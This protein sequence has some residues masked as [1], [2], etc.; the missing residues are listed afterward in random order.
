MKFEKR[1]VYHIKKYSLSLQN[2]SIQ[3]LGNFY[4]SN[5]VRNDLAYLC[6]LC[7]KNKI[8]VNGMDIRAD[9][10]FTL[11]HFPPA[12][13]SGK[14][15]ILVCKTCNDKAG[16]DFD[17]SLKEWLNEQSFIK[18][19]PNA[20][21]PVKIQPQDLKGKYR[22]NLK[23]EADKISLDDFIR[24]PFVNESLLKIIQGQVIEQTI[25]FQSPKIELVYKALIKTAYL[26][27]FSIWGYDFSYSETA[28]RIR[29]IL[30]KNEIHPLTNYGTF[31]HMDKGDNF[32]PLG[33][34]YVFKPAELQTFMITFKLISKEVNFECAISL[35]IPGAEKKCWGNLKAYQ[36]IIDTQ[37]EFKFPLIKLPENELNNTNYFP[38]TNTWNQRLNFRIV[39]EN[40]FNP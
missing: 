24:Y 22:G 19:V 12:S 36:H 27:C 5:G 9:D 4:H 17:Y 33:L 3:R 26:H 7:L 35:L 25:T 32:P 1:L 29:N 23:I 40:Y 11:D 31:F 30:F 2:V 10:D 20:K 21:L 13:V 37:E 34:Y 39:G 28:L 8:A 6:P 16:L 15:T 38:Y 18:R 14:N